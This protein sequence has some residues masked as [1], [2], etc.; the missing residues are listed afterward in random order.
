MV[1]DKT[2][3]EQF[4]EYYEKIGMRKFIK[5]ILKKIMKNGFTSK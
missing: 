3:K 2:L 5:Q 4:T 1:I